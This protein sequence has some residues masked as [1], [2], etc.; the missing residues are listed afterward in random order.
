M[1]HSK[2]RPVPNHSVIAYVSDA[3]FHN[4][5]PCNM[6]SDIEVDSLMARVRAK[7]GLSV[8]PITFIFE[9]PY[10]VLVLSDGSRES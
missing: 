2:N 9:R 3:I 7:A 10:Q 6:E 5:Q 1:L 4:D 8:S